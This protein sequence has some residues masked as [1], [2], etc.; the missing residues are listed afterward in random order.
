MISV[1]SGCVYRRQ[2]IKRVSRRNMNEQETSHIYTR[3]QPEI[4]NGQSGIRSKSSPP[5]AGTDDAPPAYTALFPPPN[6][7]P[8]A[9]KN[10]VSP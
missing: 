6:P 8:G 3:L 5:V 4:S 1:V 2:N 10:S 7:T 9:W